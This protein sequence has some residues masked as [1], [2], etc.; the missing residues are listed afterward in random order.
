VKYACHNVPGQHGYWARTMYH[1]DGKS[2]PTDGWTY[3]VNT[4]S[5]DCRYDQKETDPKCA[6]CKK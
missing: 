3:I 6:G 5:K 4:M 2:S 1:G